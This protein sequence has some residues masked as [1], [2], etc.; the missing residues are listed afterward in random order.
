MPG[1]MA[2]YVSKEKLAAAT[3]RLRLR[4]EAEGEEEEA[5]TGGLNA[6]ELEAEAKVRFI[7]R[8]A[9]ERRGG[10][11]F[12]RMRDCGA[13]AVMT[14]TFYGLEFLKIRVSAPVFT[15]RF[16]WLSEQSTRSRAFQRKFLRP[17]GHRVVD[18]A[19]AHRSVE[20]ATFSKKIIRLF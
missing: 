10:E 20:R 1:K 2:T 4:A 18:Q 15:Q 11:M 3:E 5:E 17:T 14:G 6:A 13:S 16:P 8:F 12:V 19:M 9:N 7:G